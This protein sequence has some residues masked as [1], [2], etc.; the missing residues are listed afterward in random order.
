MTMRRDLEGAL[1]TT[2]PKIFDGTTIAD[3][4]Y[5][6]ATCATCPMLLPCRNWAKTQIHNIGAGHRRG[7]GMNGGIVGLNGVV[8]G[9]VYGD[10]LKLLRAWQHRHKEKGAA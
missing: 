4:R 9:R 2:E 7:T 1:C 10:A 3:I 5:S 6:L 8:G